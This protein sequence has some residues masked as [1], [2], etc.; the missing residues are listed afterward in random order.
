[1]GWEC[2]EG[3][4]SWGVL[5]EMS[6]LFWSTVCAVC[7]SGLEGQTASAEVLRMINFPG[8]NSPGFFFHCVL[9]SSCNFSWTV[10]SG[11]DHLP[12]GEIYP[13]SCWKGNSC[14]LVSA[15]ALKNVGFFAAYWA[16]FQGWFVYVAAVFSVHLHQ[17]EVTCGCFPAAAR[18]HGRCG[19]GSFH[20][21][22]SST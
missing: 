4:G 12:K 5:V 9:K 14:G 8:Q 22:S 15:C 11:L 16:A 20:C 13:G 10:G 17:W 21:L 3:A 19:P 6:G 18:H 1:M 2:R 7:R